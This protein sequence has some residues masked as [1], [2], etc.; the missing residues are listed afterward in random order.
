MSGMG[1]KLGDNVKLPGNCH[2]NLLESMRVTLMRTPSNG[3]Y[4]VS[5]GHFCSQARLPVMA[6][7]FVC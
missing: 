3:R 6:L 4:G 5:T 2:R 7:D 1:K